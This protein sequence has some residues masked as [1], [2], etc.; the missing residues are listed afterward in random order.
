M[1]PQEIAEVKISYSSKQKVKDRT[2]ITGSEDAVNVFRSVFPSLEHIEYVYLLLLNR[3]NQVL[4][5]HLVSKGGISGTV[6]DVRVIFQVALNA[7]ATGIILA[8]NHPS[9]NL[10]VSGADRK[11]TEQICEA[12]KFLDIPLL[13]HVILT[14][15]SYLSMADDGII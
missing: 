4:G 13:D 14:E 6:I 1:I 10:S 12:G 8:H 7:N 2:K 9:G 3:Q 11:I 15:D 5:Y